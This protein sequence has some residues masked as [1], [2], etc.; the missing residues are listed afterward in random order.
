[1]VSSRSL[2]WW[3]CSCLLLG[4][5]CGPEGVKAIEE[6][7]TDTETDTDA[8]TESTTSGSTTFT[9][10]GPTT[11]LTTA[12][13]S[14]ADE[15]AEPPSASTTDDCPVGTEN[16]LCDVGAACEDGLS[17]ED[18]ICV[19]GPPCAQPEGEPNGDEASAVELA[20]L[21]CGDPP[22]TTSGVLDGV[23]ADW[24]TFH[25]S[26]GIA[27]F[28]GP[29]AQVTADADVVLC[30]Y[31]ECDEGNTM[32]QCSPPSNPSDS[33]DGRSGCCGTNGVEVGSVDCGFG[34][35][36]SAQ[37]FVRATAVDAACMA[38]ELEYEF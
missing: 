17:C 35:G 15:T 2:Q 10:A 18:G 37:V 27:C 24:Y 32:V 30:M 21:G 9:T 3:S 36:D 20:D 1:M 12:N 6:T 13:T 8:E 25:G 19:S 4:L 29:S 34:N 31:F 16:C 38:Y 7:D 5:A 28:G 11:G 14:D 23:D 22:E 26:A 33:P